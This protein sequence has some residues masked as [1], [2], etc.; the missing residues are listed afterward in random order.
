VSVLIV[1]LGAC[2]WL[3]TKAGG[4]LGRDGTPSI[5]ALEL[6]G[7]PDD[8]GR[9]V[10]IW[11]ERGLIDGAISGVHADFFFLLAYSTG[12]ALSCVM[13]IAPIDRSGFP[14]TGVG[15][16]LAWLQSVAGGL[17]AL[18]NVALLRML[19]GHLDRPWPE[20]SRVCASLKFVLVLGGIA[21]ALVGV[22]L[23]VF[24]RVTHSHAV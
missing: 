9:I 15:I 22:V 12:L 3:G 8:A 21:F 20:V 18:E 1:L 24:E 17:D 2:V 16:P 10:S 23:W 5:V 14:G 13:A 11:R 4:G 19:R 6:A 7:T